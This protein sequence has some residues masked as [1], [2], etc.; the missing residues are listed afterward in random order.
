MVESV[1]SEFR[2]PQGAAC[3]EPHQQNNRGQWGAVALWL[4]AAF[5]TRSQLEWKDISKGSDVCVIPVLTPAEAARIHGSEPAPHPNFIDINHRIVEERTSLR[6]STS[7][8]TQPPSILIPGTHT[9]EVL[10]SIGIDGDRINNLQKQ[11]A[12]GHQTE[13]RV[14]AGL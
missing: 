10:R 1:G 12:L 13:G 7:P 3:L 8:V 9:F 11:G 14:K 4:E 5:K 6:E 2:A